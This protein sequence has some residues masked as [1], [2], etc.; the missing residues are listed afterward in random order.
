MM[1]AVQPALVYLV[2]GDDGAALAYAGGD[3]AAY[4]EARGR[5][6]PAHAG[7]LVG[8]CMAGVERWLMVCYFH[9]EPNAVDVKRRRE[10]GLFGLAWERSRD[11]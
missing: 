1:A 4:R 3:E 11:D 7:A 8:Q 6:E 10:S 9:E 2:Y 5:L